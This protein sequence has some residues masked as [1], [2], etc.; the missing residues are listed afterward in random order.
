MSDENFQ[1]NFGNENPNSHHNTRSELLNSQEETPSTLPQPLTNYRETDSESLRSTNSVGDLTSS[2]IEDTSYIITSNNNSDTNFINPSIIGNSYSRLSRTIGSFLNRTGSTAS[3]EE[4][5]QD[6]TSILNRNEAAHSFVADMSS[7]SNSFSTS[8][9]SSAYSLFNDESKN[10]KSK[11]HSKTSKFNSLNSKLTNLKKQKRNA[12]SNSVMRDKFAYLMSNCENYYKVMT[13]PMEDTFNTQAT[14]S[15]IKSSLE[16]INSLKKLKHDCHDETDQDALELLEYT[17][18]IENELQEFKESTNNM[19]R[20]QDFHLCPLCSHC[21]FEPVTLVCGCTFCK[22]CLKELNSDMSSLQAK[23]SH[24]QQK[25]PQHRPTSTWLDSSDSESNDEPFRGFLLKRKF[26][27]SNHASSRLEADNFRCYNCGKDHD[28]N[29]LNILRQN[30][31]L[32]DTVDKF[33]S[34]NV[35]IRKL[36]N[37]IRNYIC[38]CLESNMQ[39]FD[40]DK[41]EYMLKDAY[42][43]DPSNH[44]LLADLFLLNYF[45]DFNKDCIRYAKMAC[46]LRP[47]WIFVSL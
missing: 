15:N 16:Q 24:H 5:I 47:D 35:E 18:Q 19:R 29:S 44:L 26:N 41:F 27:R 46:E 43:Q 6:E 42:N 30:V 38:F 32:T 3:I 28:H 36:R 33:W 2:R 45:N 11:F 13:L 31:L 25:Q 23:V 17:S 34:K 4:M 1:T 21:L 10:L 12:N 7:N 20:N 8:T 9:S 14:T 40:L 39:E 37:D 22:K